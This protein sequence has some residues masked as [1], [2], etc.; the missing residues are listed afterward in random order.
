MMLIFRLYTVSVEELA[1]QDQHAARLEHA[2]IVTTVSIA[3]GF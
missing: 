3:R 2:N 1:I